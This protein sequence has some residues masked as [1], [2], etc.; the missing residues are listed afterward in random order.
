MLLLTTLTLTLSLVKTSLKDLTSVHVVKV[1]N[2]SDMTI[3]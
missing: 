3:G 2:D 1:A